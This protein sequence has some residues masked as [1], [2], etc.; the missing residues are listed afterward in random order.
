[1]FRGQGIG[2]LVVSTRIHPGECAKADGAS[3]VRI[4]TLA[5][6]RAARSS[7]FLSN[8]DLI[9]IIGRDPFS[10]RVAQT[11]GQSSICLSSVPKKEPNAGGISW[12]RTTE[13][14]PESP[15][16]FQTVV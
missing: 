12:T 11:Q 6:R 3:A 2:G 15:A 9:R 10:R 4:D 1:M 5:T 13:R 16:F 8:G 14:R 7:T